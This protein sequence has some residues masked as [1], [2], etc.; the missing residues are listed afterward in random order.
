MIDLKLTTSKD[1]YEFLDNNGVRF[2]KLWFETSYTNTLKNPDVKIKLIQINKLWITSEYRR[3]GVGNFL[4]KILLK[5]F[6]DGV[7]I[8]LASPDNKEDISLQD[9]IK[10]YEKFEFKIIYNAYESALMILNKISN[11]EID[12]KLRG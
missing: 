11:D 6:K 3:L 4:M 12:W 10:F 8:L 1:G 7:F 5:D 2:A 9:L